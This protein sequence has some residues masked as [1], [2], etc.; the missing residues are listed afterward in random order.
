MSYSPRRVASAERAP[1]NPNPMHRRHRIVLV[2]ACLMLSVAAARTKTLTIYFIDVEGGQATLVVTP[3]GQSLL[4]DAG[5]PGF[6]DRDPDRIVA[7]AK[8]AGISQIDDL[9][10]THFHGDH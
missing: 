6:N 9:L 4:V 1:Y 7:A 8:D 5:W 10:V 2:A 3:A